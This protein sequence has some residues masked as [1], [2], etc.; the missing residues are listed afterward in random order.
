MPYSRSPTALMQ[1]LDEHQHLISDGEY[2]DVCTLLQR[3]HRVQLVE[4]RQ[5]EEAAEMQSMGWED[6]ARESR[7][8]RR[9]IDHVCLQVQD[10]VHDKLRALARR[11]RTEDVAAKLAA[12]MA[13][14]AANT[15]D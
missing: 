7:R 4:K 15:G 9:E 11:A 6:V 1:R 10:Y 12:D 2:L 14:R 5:R 8:T 13:E 3:V